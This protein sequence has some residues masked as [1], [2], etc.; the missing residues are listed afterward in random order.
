MDR[1]KGKQLQIFFNGLADVG[2]DI[3][4]D[5]SPLSNQVELVGK[6][7][8]SMKAAGFDTIG[9]KYNRFRLYT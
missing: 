9:I 8:L 7:V 6:G 5:L 1:C 4:D 3:E 2:T